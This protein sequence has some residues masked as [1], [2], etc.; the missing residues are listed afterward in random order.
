MRRALPNMSAVAG[1]SCRLLYES[2]EVSRPFSRPSHSSS[3][4]SPSTFPSS[5]CSPQ[6]LGAGVRRGSSA[7]PH[8]KCQPPVL[9]FCPQNR[10]VSTRLSLL[11]AGDGTNP[12]PSRS[13]QHSAQKLYHK[14]VFP[15]LWN[16]DSPGGRPPFQG[17]VTQYAGVRVTLQPASPRT[18]WM[19]H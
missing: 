4:W 2:Y 19:Q 9:P 16:L 17:V 10:T 14:P 6:P 5:G 8:T 11:Q 7:G 18:L 13:T 3:T 15:L 1:S 12:G